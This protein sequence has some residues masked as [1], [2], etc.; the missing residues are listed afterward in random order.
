MEKEIN[1]P[2]FN[3]VNDSKKLTEKKREEIFEYRTNPKLV[4]TDEDGLSDGEEVLTYSSNPRNHDSDGDGILETRDSDLE[5]P[6]LQYWLLH[7]W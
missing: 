5:H 7:E 2:I 1:N 3:N 4:D 6:P